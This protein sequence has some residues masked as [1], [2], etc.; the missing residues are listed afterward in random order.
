MAAGGTVGHEAT[1]LSWLL[2]VVAAADLATFSAIVPLLPRY[3]DRLGLS[4]FEIGIVVASYAVAVLAVAIPAGRASDRLGKRTMTVTSV[5]GMAVATVLFV[6]ASS[7]P[8]LVAARFLQG[9]ASGVAWSAGLA[10][11]SEASPPA[12]RAGTVARMTTGASAGLVAGPMIGGVLGHVI[13]IRSSF[14]LI[15]VVCAASASGLALIHERRPAAVAATSLREG[16][17]TGARNPDIRIGVILVSA[18]AMAGAGMQ[19]LVP[20]HLGR[21]GIS[22]FAIGLV[23][24]GSAGGSALIGFAVSRVTG[25]F[26]LAVAAGIASAV[27]TGTIALL[28][29]PLPV[30]A[31]AVVTIVQGSLQTILYVAGFALSAEGAD[32]AGLGQGLVMGVVNLAWG[33]AAFL[34]PLVAGALGGGVGDAAAYLVLAVV[35]AGAVAAIF[36][37]RRPAAARA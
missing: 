5:A 37:W 6:F 33:A 35:V 23:Y 3:A 29:L 34:G 26:D 19:T 32:A 2:F 24:A 21:E 4:S 17:R 9:A 30:V 7:F 15:A 14:L 12:E 22:A 8:A 16:V 28:T 1:R 20:L 10:W 18:V 31:I 13:G 25:R 27:L 36:A 11:L